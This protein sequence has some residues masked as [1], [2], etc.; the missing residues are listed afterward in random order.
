MKNETIK[1]AVTASVFWGALWGITEA[2]LGYLAHMISIIPGIAG[3]I[4]FPIGYYFMTRAFKTTG[5]HWS[6][7]GVAS[8]AAGIKL[9]DLLL[10]GLNLIYTINPAICILMEA[11]ALVFVLM[12]MGSSDKESAMFDFKRIWVIG[13]GWRFV[14]FVYSSIL[15]AF[16]ISP[17]FIQKGAWHFSRFLVLE[18]IVNALIITFFMKTG[19][20]ISFS[21]IRIRPL[22]AACAFTT[23]VLLKI[24][25]I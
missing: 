25:V 10:P 14:F 16:S 20:Y 8:I 15:F 13:A 17:E 24:A 22:Y 11:L 18:P 6:I 2:T 12:F 9:I 19:K 21:S 3:F 23:A 5:K 1:K 4:M 7:F